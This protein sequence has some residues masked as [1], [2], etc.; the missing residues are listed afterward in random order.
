MGEI[1]PVCENL[2]ARLYNLQNEL[3]FLENKS[4]VLS[5]HSQTKYTNTMDK[6]LR[7]LGKNS[8]KSPVYHVI[9]QN[10]VARELKS[11]HEDVSWLFFELLDVAPVDQVG[12]RLSSTGNSASYCTPRQ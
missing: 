4:R 5:T 12:R 7:F 3:Q 11:L 6:F 8:G 1:R 10:L 9:K 2:Y